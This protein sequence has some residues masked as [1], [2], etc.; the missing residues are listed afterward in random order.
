MQKGAAMKTLLRWLKNENKNKPYVDVVF[1]NLIGKSNQVKNLVSREKKFKSVFS[2]GRKSHRKKQFFVYFFYLVLVTC[3][4]YIN[5]RDKI[6]IV[7][8]EVNYG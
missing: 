7:Y 8:K 2:L 5:F 4:I 1:R 3:S 6:V